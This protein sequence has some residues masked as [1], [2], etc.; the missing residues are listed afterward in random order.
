MK[1][2]HLYADESGESHFREVII[3]SK[4][5]Q[6]GSSQSVSLIA[7]SIPLNSMVIRQVVEEGSS[8]PTWHPNPRRQFDLFLKGRVEIEAS[9]GEVR[10]LGP[11]DFFFAED[12]FGK[13][14]LFRPLEGPRWTMFLEVQEDWQLPMT[15]GTE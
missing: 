15:G 9:D 2:L 1:I 14:H 5:T 13:G 3:P 12:T 8:T 7:D 6:Y 11:G 4:M 10:Q